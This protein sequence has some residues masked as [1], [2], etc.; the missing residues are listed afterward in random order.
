MIRYLL[1]FLGLFFWG[2]STVL[3]AQ[4]H[5]CGISHSDATS[6]KNR[7]LDNRRQQMNLLSIFE[8]ARG[9]GNTVYIPVQFH[10][11]TKSDGTGGE[12]VQHVLDNLCKLNTDFAFVGVEFY[13]YS[14]IRFVHQDLLYTNNQ[15]GM[16]SYFM[17]L[18][19]ESNVVNIFVGNEIVDTSGG[20][21]LGYYSPSLDAIYAIKDAVDGSSLTLTHEAGHF[22]SLP[23][24]FS[25]WE[26]R[27]YNTVTANANGRTPTFLSNGDEV[28]RIIRSG[29]GENC[30]IAGDGFCDTD[31]NYLFGYYGNRYNVG[32]FLCEHASAAIDP[33]GKLFRPDLIRP[34]TRFKMKEDNPAFT[35]LLTTN[36][37]TGSYFPTKTLLVVESSFTPTG[38]QPTS[39]WKDTIG[40]T[41]STDYTLRTAS[42]MI[43]PGNVKEGFIS[44]GDYYLDLKITNG[45]NFQMNTVPAQY[46]VSAGGTYTTEMASLEIISTLPGTILNGLVITVEEQLKHR[47]LGVVSS[48]TW[49]IPVTVPIPTGVTSLPIA[50]L[51]KQ[52]QTIAGCEFSIDIRA[53][54][55]N[56]TETTAD[57]IM[58]Y[59]SNDCK[60]SF[61]TEQGLAMKMDIASRGLA[62]LY[63]APSTIQITGQ[64]A[65]IYPPMNAVTPN[66]VNFSWGA[67]SGATSYHLYVYEVDALGNPAF[68]G[69]TY[70]FISTATN[71]SASLSPLTRY[72][73]TITPL[74]DISFCDP[75]IRSTP[76][77]FETEAVGVISL[78]NDL[79]MIKMYPNPTGKHQAVTLELRAK[80]QKE[81]QILVLNSLGQTVMP[82]Q[83]LELQKG[84]NVQKLDTKVLGAGLYM[85]VIKTKE[86]TSSQKLMIEN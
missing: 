80:E 8:D 65:M 64:A 71:F 43:G 11:V 81:V 44:M 34:V 53:P 85:V 58:S 66:T 16:A 2:N 15:D 26:E 36:A 17:G 86:G 52:K 55:G 68:N 49:T 6:I 42:N 40:D 28:E 63:P 22:F 30:Q 38:G 33:T 78:N 20:V 79:E 84:V 10:I 75:T 32:P 14:P 61:S 82:S 25:G 72:A 4:N 70:D 7:M 59:Y 45:L 73:W 57:N 48:E 35:E 51:Y 60:T 77:I 12:S 39:M 31:P 5:Q 69:E 54:Y 37:F 24:T 9:G 23:H 21:T 27:N 50:D 47:T 74:N 62:T 46:T 19:K 13:L 76:V 67:V 3:V 29:G 83:T 41:D 1:F 56:V 18:Y